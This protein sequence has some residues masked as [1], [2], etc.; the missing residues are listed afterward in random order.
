VRHRPRQAFRL[1][2]YAL[3]RK[4]WPCAALWDAQQPQ[5]QGMFGAGYDGGGKAICA[6][7]LPPPPPQ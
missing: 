6:A 1:A 4:G 5:Q 3:A 7:L 2:G